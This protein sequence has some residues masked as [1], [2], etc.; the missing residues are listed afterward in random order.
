[1]VQVVDG[2]TIEIERVSAAALP[3]TRVRMIAVDTPEVHGEYGPEASEL[4]KKQ[5]T[6]KTVCLKRGL[7]KTN[8]HG[9]TL[10]YV[11]L[12]EPPADPTGQQ[13]ARGCSTLS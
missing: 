10:R 4:A 13:T 8:R 5:L 3:A 12:V 11:L 9:R 6:G 1:M 7:S 2:D